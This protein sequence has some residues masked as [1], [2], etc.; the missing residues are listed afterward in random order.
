MKYFILFIT[1]LL[2]GCAHNEV[3]PVPIKFPEGYTVGVKK[4]PPSC[5]KLKTQE[6]EDIPIPVLLQTIA[7]NYKL[8]YDCAEHVEKWNEWYRKQKENFEKINR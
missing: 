5:L 3:V 2:A 8:Y 1:M 4:E 6:G 7:E